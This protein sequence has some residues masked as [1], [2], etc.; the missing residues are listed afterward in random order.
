[1][2]TAAAVEVEE[3][4][5]L[6]EAVNILYNIKSPRERAASFVRSI[7]QSANL[8][9]R[10]VADN[11]WH[12]RNLSVEQFDAWVLLVRDRANRILAAVEELAS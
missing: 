10:E 1:M 2:N 9:E 3:R 12:L 11:V 4:T 7:D 8:L 5:A 6:Q